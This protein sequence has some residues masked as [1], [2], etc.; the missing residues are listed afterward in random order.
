MQRLAVGISVSG[1]VFEGDDFVR[2]WEG[3]DD[4]LERYNANI[5]SFLPIISIS[6]LRNLYYLCYYYV[7]QVR[8]AVGVK[9]SDCC[10]HCDS[11]LVNIK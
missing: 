7:T 3:I 2:P 8:V 10:E 1:F 9:E 4:N 6:F 5:F 11:G